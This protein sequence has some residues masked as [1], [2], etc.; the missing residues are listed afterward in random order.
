MRIS[1][2]TI[3]VFTALMYVIGCSRDSDSGVVA[4]TPSVLEGVWQEEFEHRY[5][6][7]LLQRMSTLSITGTE[8]TV[9]V[10]PPRRV[11]VV[12]DGHITTG[13]S[14]DTL[15]TGTCSA[16]ADTLR[17]CRNDTRTHAF[18]FDLDGSELHVSMLPVSDPDSDFL[19]LGR[20][21]LWAYSMMKHEGSF[22]AVE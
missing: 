21:F 2:L 15:Y 10:L 12:E 1:V 18:L 5:F 17:L 3:L 11:F 6:I 22:T 16:V 14:A 8:F 13:W 9:T 20:S 19:V 7:E 4:P